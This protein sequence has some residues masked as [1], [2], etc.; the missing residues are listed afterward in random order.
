MLFLVII[1]AVIHQSVC[2]I[3]LLCRYLYVSISLIVLYNYKTIDSQ[4][5]RIKKTT[6]D[7]MFIIKIK[8][9]KGGFEHRV[10][11][12]YPIREQDGVH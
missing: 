1:K 4:H 3:V 11:P 2:S 5:G 10:T 8:K 7:H 9:M 6:F 12:F